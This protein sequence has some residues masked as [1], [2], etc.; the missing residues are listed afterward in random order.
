MANGGSAD[1]TKSG[2]FV[3]TSAYA[4]TGDVCMDPNPNPIRKKRHVESELEPV[5]ERVVAGVEGYVYTVK[6]H[7]GKVVLCGSTGEGEC[8]GYGGSH[9]MSVR[10]WGLFRSVICSDLDQP[11]FPEAFYVVQWASQVPCSPKAS[12]LTSTP[13]TPSWKTR[14]SPPPPAHAS[15]SFQ[16]PQVSPITAEPDEAVE[17]NTTAE[18]VDHPLGMLSKKF[19]D[20][21]KIG[22]IHLLNNVLY[23]YWEELCYGCQIN[24][25]SQKEI[26]WYFYEPH[27]EA[28]D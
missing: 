5:F 7:D 13:S 21:V 27:E 20:N 8:W 28:L 12:S 24:H 3:G 22:V 25:P 14:G 1:F 16:T 6:Y 11:G 17:N 26:P 10:D 15:P 2:D 18:S 19:V 4:V 23:K 9:S